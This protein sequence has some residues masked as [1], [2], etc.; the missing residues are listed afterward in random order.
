MHSLSSVGIQLLAHKRLKLS[1]ALARSLAFSHQATSRNL[2]SICLR[3]IFPMVNYC[4]AR[5]RIS[6][7]YLRIN[8]AY[9]RPL[10]STDDELHNC[11]RILFGKCRLVSR[12]SITSFLYFRIY[13]TPCLFIIYLLGF[14]NHALTA[15]FIEELDRRTFKK[16]HC[17]AHRL[18]TAWHCECL[19]FFFF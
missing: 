15:G 14:E 17:M 10:L 16:Q 6:D 9:Y 4:L 1:F 7:T 19:F 12:S 3:V 11:Q 8:Q 18:G 2:C 13:F 5:H